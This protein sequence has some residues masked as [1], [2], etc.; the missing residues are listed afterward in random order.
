MASSSSGT[1][2]P[3]TL[4][5]NDETPSMYS[6][7]STSTR[8]QPWARSMMSGGSMAYSCIGV[9]GCQTCSRSH[10]AN[11]ARVGSIAGFLRSEE[12]LDGHAD[13]GAKPFRGIPSVDGDLQQ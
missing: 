10:C 3:W 1:R 4:H 6:R 8:K 11:C 9:N 13:G 5:H 12:H 7:P 2:W